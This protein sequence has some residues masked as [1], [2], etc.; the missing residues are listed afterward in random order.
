[1]SRQILIPV[2]SGLGK[3]LKTAILNSYMYLLW[4]AMV[5]NV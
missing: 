5:R 2:A 3:R 1:M 4:L